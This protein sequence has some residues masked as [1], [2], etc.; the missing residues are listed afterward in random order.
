MERQPLAA[1][2][3]MYSVGVERTVNLGN[4]EN[5]RIGLVKSFHDSQTSEDDAYAHVKDTVDEWAMKLKPSKKEIKEM[6]EKAL[7]TPQPQIGNIPPGLAD[8][9]QHLEIN[10]TSNHIRIRLT[11]YVGKPLWDKINGQVKNL[12]GRWVGERETGD[13]RDVYWEIPK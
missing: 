6:V 4:Y 8:F 12:G 11:R 7:P 5:I 2:P 3:G 9:A 13:K 10:E 1:S